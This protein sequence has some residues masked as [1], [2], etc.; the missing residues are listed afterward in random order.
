MD[1]NKLMKVAWQL[2][3][4][5][6]SVSRLQRAAIEQLANLLQGR[7]QALRQARAQA[8]EALLPPPTYSRLFGVAQALDRLEGQLLT[9]DRPW[10]V[11]LVGIGGIGKTALAD[12]TIR[13][14]IPHFRFDEVLWL[15]AHFHSMRGPA[16]AE[17]EERGGPSSPQL[18][19]DGVVADI[20]GR[21]FPQRE[22]DSPNQRLLQVRQA[23]KN[24]PYLVVIDNLENEAN[25]AFLLA[26]L[27]N[28]A[29]PSKFLLTTRSRPSEQATVFSFSLDELPPVDAADLIRHHAREVGVTAVDT[30]TEADIGDIYELTGGNPLA[31]KLVV[32]LLDVLPLPQILADFMRGGKGPIE[33]LYRHIYMKTWQVLS[34]AARTL[35][36][37]MPLVAESGALPEY[38]RAI[39]SLTEAELWPALQELRNRSLLEAQGTVQAKR[40]GI[41]R[42]TE[43]FL[44]TEIIHWPM[45]QGS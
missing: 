25:T 29:Q 15:R 26:Q 24:R 37:A 18:I 10:V 38:M 39:T 21:L 2:N 45:E 5:E 6:H 16:E 27:S 19:F 30:A 3:V 12:A 23:L 8:T 33:D 11:A 42:L 36:Q 14:I 20:A 28:L 17:G 35:L 44:Q 7:E 43:T 22:G 1:D 40:Y 13:R 31:L 4:S 34:P 41:H 32:G 9:S